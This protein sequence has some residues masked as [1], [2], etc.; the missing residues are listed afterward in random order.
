MYCTITRKKHNKA[1]RL[2]ISGPQAE[3]PARSATAIQLQPVRHDSFALPGNPVFSFNELTPQQINEGSHG[4]SYNLT[5]QNGVQLGWESI[6]GFSTA[7]NQFH[8]A[9]P[10]SANPNRRGPD[11]PPSTGTQIVTRGVSG[12]SVFIVSYGSHHVMA[13]LDLPNIN[14]QNK[15]VMKDTLASITDQV[16]LPAQNTPGNYVHPDIFISIHNKADSTREP[17]LFARRLIRH[18]YPFIP[19]TKTPPAPGQSLLN[20]LTNGVPAGHHIRILDRTCIGHD[21]EPDMFNHPEIGLYLDPSTGLQIFGDIRGIDTIGTNVSVHDY[22]FLI[23]LT[24][25]QT[26]FTAL[27]I[28]GQQASDQAQQA[29]APARVARFLT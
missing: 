19:K 7:G 10:I 4:I 25:P 2:S 1:P 12:C 3:N 28:L 29:N 21:G 23:N 6:L 16:P 18:Y 26:D 27:Q 20:Y 9:A 14:H 22:P 5:N 17:A 8:F 11:L 24:D 13:H 15:P